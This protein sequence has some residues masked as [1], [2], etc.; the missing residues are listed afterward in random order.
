VNWRISVLLVDDHAVVREGYRRLMERTSD[1][2]VIAEASNGEDAYRIYG[3]TP[4]DVVVMDVS[5]PGMSGIETTRRMLAR[6]PAARVL[7]FSM[8]EDAMFASRALQAGAKGY[9]TKSSAPEVLVEAVRSVASGKIYITQDVAQQLAMQSLP[10]Q[11]LPLNTLSP[12]EFEVFRLLAQGVG[13]PDIAT[14]LSLSQKTIANYQ[15]S[16]RQKLEV[17]NAAQIVRLAISCGLA[18]AGAAIPELDLSA[19]EVPDPEQS[20]SHATD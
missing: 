13:V 4:I 3:E 12:R 18:E 8:H 9:V 16:I 17:T 14:R 10:G 1:L 11:R 6:S 19:G 15:S 5:L 7:V 2:K 20:D